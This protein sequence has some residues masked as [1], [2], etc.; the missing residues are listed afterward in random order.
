M[1]ISGNENLLFAAP[2]GD[3]GGTLVTSE[4]DV[5]GCIVKWALFI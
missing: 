4:Q 3:F 5:V 2:D 1:G